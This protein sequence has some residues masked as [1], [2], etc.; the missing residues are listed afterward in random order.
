M[1]DS[2]IQ[3]CSIVHEN[4]AFILEKLHRFLDKD[5]MELLGVV[6]PNLWFRRNAVVY[7]KLNSPYNTVV[8]NAYNSLIALKDANSHKL[9]WTIGEM[10]LRWEAPMDGFVKVNWDTA[11]ETNKNKMGIC[12]IIRDSKG[13]LLA[14][15]SEPKDHIIAPE[16]AEAISALRAV[17][18]SHGLGFYK[19][20][21]EGDALQI[22]QALGKEGSNWCIYGHLIEETRGILHNMQNWKVHHVRRNLNGAA[23]LFVRVALSLSNAHVCVEETPQCIYDIIVIE[24]CT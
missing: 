20:I 2:K 19:V 17:H 3:K 10:D 22:V 14:T 15:L 13:E 6:V 16:I 5:D 4:F 12:V 8:S 21:L 24:R 18:F 1:C 11:V 9:S 23:H 7:G